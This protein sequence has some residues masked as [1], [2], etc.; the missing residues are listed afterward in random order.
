VELI[1]PDEESREAFGG[2]YLDASRRGASV[3]AGIKQ[4]SIEAGRI[5]EFWA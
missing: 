5:K 1:V 2:S 3:E 4:G